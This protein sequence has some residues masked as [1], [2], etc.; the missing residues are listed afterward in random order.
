MPKVE[1][2][3]LPAARQCLRMKSVTQCR[4]TI[5]VNIFQ[6]YFLSFEPEFLA[7]F[8]EEEVNAHI[9]ERWEELSDT[10]K[11]V[12]CIQYSKYSSLK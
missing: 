2:R 7:E 5:Q 1:K 11:Q 4:T 6:F 3:E 9:D 10:K 8:D 12:G